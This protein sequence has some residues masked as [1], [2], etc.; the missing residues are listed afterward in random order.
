MD[1]SEE[2][3]EFIWYEERWEGKNWLGVPLKNP[4]DGHIEGKYMEVVTTPKLDERTGEHIDNAFA[5]T[6]E[7]YYIPFTKKNVD[8]IIASSS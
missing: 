4:I 7:S 5:G 3:K 2:R 1:F 6:R 8:E